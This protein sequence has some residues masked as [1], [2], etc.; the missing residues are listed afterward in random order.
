VLLVASY[1]PG[2]AREL[3]ALVEAA[4]H[5]VVTLADVGLGGE[6]AAAYEETGATY[7]ENAMGKARHYGRLSGRVTI[8]DDSGLEVEALGGRPGVQSARYGGPGLDDAGRNRRLLDELRGVPDEKRAAQYVAVAVV[9]RP[10]G[11]VRSFR[12][13]CAGRIAG[14]PRGARGFGYDPLFFFPPFDATFAEVDP[15]R[16]HAVSHRGKALRA[17]AEFLAGADGRRFLLGEI[18]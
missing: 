11:A 9:A 1:N 12:G 13:A 17:L 16:K 8:A 2:K 18:A 14:A 6:G 7:E 5:T 10:D 4:G 3:R 15:A